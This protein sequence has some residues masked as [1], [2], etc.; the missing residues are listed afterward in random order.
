MGISCHRCDELAKLATDESGD[1]FCPRCGVWVDPPTDPSP[2]S[3]PN[4]DDFVS[5]E[6][7]VP[8][9]YW[10]LPQVPPLVGASSCNLPLLFGGRCRLPLDHAGGC[11]P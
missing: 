1:W 9:T 4:I 10:P 7:S 5:E 8:P 3:V 2:P 11:S 6:E